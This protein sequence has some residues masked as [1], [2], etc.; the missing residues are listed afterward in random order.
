M[1]DQLMTEAVAPISEEER[2]IVR[3]RMRLLTLAAYIRGGITAAFSC[4]FLIYVLMFSVIAGMPESAWT[5]KDN[6][7]THQAPAI[8]SDPQASPSPTTRVYNQGCGPPKAL[9]GILAAMFAGFTLLGWTIG[10]L[11]AYAGWC[12]RQRQRKLLVLIVSGFN[13]VFLPYGTL[14]GVAAILVLSSPT[15]KAEFERGQS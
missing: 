7:G 8:S 13:C 2:I 15:G 12:I 10:G 9:F 6:S 11:T 5:N 1:S 3:E 14:F 4:F